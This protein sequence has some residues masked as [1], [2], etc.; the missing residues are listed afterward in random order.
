MYR[1]RIES[2]D[3]Q[4]HIDEEIREIE[5]SGFA[6]IVD[7]EKSSQVILHNVSRMDIANGIAFDDTMMGAAIIAK[8]MREAHEMDRKS[9]PLGSLLKSLKN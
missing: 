4:D 9:D 8:A 3:G 1:I 7:N 5:C 2:M 6:I